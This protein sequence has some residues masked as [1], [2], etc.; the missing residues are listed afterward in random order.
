MT[1]PCVY[2]RLHLKLT[3]CDARILASARPCVVDLA[4]TT[5]KSA[6][7][8]SNEVVF[9]QQPIAATAKPLLVARFEPLPAFQ[10]P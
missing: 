4:G 8:V 1:Q 2:L 3:G 7:L 10:S 9:Y 5:L 6:S